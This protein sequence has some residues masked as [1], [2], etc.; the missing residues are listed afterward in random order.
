M[1][2]EI[3]EIFG[4]EDEKEGK[5]R[6]LASSSNPLLMRLR[7]ASLLITGHAK[8]PDALSRLTNMQV[9]TFSVFDAIREKTL[10]FQEIKPLPVVNGS[11][12]RSTRAR[13]FGPEGSQK[14]NEVYIYFG[15][16]TFI[17]R[18]KSMSQSIMADARKEYLSGIEEKPVQL[19]YGSRDDLDIPKPSIYE[20]I[21]GKP[22]R[23]DGR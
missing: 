3:Q 4:L 8:F 1:A 20:A 15:L 14:M 9:S 6:K 10:K 7:L 11:R 18:Y 5:T 22:K 12:Y 16:N 2:D 13:Y 19:R 23:D 21:T 17:H